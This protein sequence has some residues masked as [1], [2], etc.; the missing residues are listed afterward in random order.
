MQTL[1][2]IEVGSCNTMYGYWLGNSITNGFDN[3]AIGCK[4]LYDSDAD[5]TNN[6]IIGNG[7]GS[8]LS[9]L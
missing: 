4:A 5:V 8:N 9:Q 2:S 6:I 1:N 3:I 7:V